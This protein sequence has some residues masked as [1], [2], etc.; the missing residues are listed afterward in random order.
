M[1]EI[2]DTYQDP[3]ARAMTFR[4][5]EAAEKTRGRARRAPRWR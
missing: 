2:F 3:N 1:Q 5:F 4:R